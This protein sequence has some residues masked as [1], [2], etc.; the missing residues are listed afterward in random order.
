MR[1]S[2]CKNRC[3]MSGFCRTLLRPEYPGFRRFAN[4]SHIL[5]FLQIPLADQSGFDSVQKT[6]QLN[7]VPGS[8]APEHP[9]RS[10]VHNDSWPRTLDGTA[11]CRPAGPRSSR[12]RP[13]ISR[14]AADVRKSR[15][16]PW[17]SIRTLSLR[18]RHNPSPPRFASANTRG[19]FLRRYY[20]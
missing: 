1:R 6:G 18:S 14:A 9:R 13:G 5:G 3:K 4:S 15:T 12:T 11:E 19:S 2:A 16:W 7:R 17:A 20:V 10:N 8:A